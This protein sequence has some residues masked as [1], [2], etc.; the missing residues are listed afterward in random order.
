MKIVMQGVVQDSV[1]NHWW[2]QERSL[3]FVVVV[4]EAYPILSCLSVLSEMWCCVHSQASLFGIL[5][6]FK[7]S[8]IRSL[9]I[10]SKNSLRNI[11]EGKSTVPPTPQF[12]LY[13]LSNF[14]VYCRFCFLCVYRFVCILSCATH[15]VPLPTLE[16]ALYK[17]FYYYKLLKLAVERGNV[18]GSQIQSHQVHSKKHPEGNHAP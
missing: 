8:Y 15:W 18:P 5:F 7:L 13:A 9:Q 10:R 14:F 2:D 12:V 11:L 1:Y 17:I 16:N 4:V 3:L 6:L